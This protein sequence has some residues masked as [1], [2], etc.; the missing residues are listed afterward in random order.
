[1]PDWMASTDKSAQNAMIFRSKLMQKAV[2]EL[3]LES[4][5]TSVARSIKSQSHARRISAFW[6][7]KAVDHD[8]DEGGEEGGFIEDYLQNVPARHRMS[9]DAEDLDIME[10]LGEGGGHGI[11]Q[12]PSRRML[13]KKGS[14]L[15]S[16]VEEG[17]DEEGEEGGGKEDEDE[18]EEEDVFVDEPGVNRESIIRNKGGREEVSSDEPELW[19]V[20]GTE[21]DFDGQYKFGGQLWYVQSR[22]QEAVFKGAPINGKPMNEKARAR[23]RKIIDAQTNRHPSMRELL[24]QAA[25]EGG[26]GAGEGSAGGVLGGAAEGTNL[27][28]LLVGEADGVRKERESMS[29]ERK[30]ELEKERVMDESLQGLLIGAAD[31]EELISPDKSKAAGMELG[32]G[33]E[34]GGEGVGDGG[35]GGRD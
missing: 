23:Q 15:G 16:M 27:Y 18:D 9:I 20:D 25:E 11:Q 2:S 13:Q 12:M 10:A 5:V 26:G 24:F 33:L 4:H 34:G 28:E 8:R 19:N 31:M 3:L 32:E 21:V 1:M 22:V 35:G 17:E 29:S 14:N 6:L 7:Q 30:K